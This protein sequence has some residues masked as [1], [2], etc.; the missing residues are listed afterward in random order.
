MSENGGDP[1]PVPWG[2]VLTL[3]IE[4]DN[5]FPVTVMIFGSNHILSSVITLGSVNH[6]RIVLS[7]GPRMSQ[8]VLEPIYI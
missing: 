7:L 6:K 8:S 5:L 2:P 4:E 1:V 3:H